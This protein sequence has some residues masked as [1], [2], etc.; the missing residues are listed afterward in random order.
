[1]K[2]CPSPALKLPSYQ[3]SGKLRITLIGCIRCVKCH[4]TCLS[5]H[6]I[7]SSP[8]KDGPSGR[9]PQQWHEA[10]G[11]VSHGIYLLTSVFISRVVLF[12]FVLFSPCW[13]VFVNEGYIG[14]ILER[15]W[16]E[17]WINLLQTTFRHN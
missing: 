12:S 2:T 5:L 8:T 15:L 6:L 11:E 16:V 10:E 7:S 3:N 17:K 9:I 13:L 4:F 14:V 1:M